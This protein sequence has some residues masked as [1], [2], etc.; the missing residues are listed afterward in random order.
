MVE[1][2]NKLEKL[3]EYFAAKRVDWS[4]KIRE[5]IYM[6]RNVKKLDE[7]IVL[8]LSY[9][10]MVLESLTELNVKSHKAEAAYKSQY[11]V[12]YM[13]YYNHDYKLNDKQKDSMVKADLIE[14][15]KQINLFENQIEFYRESIKTLDNM[16]WAIKSRISVEQM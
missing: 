16:G 15:R 4:D 3:E 6:M 8:M 2:E 10:Q 7:A 5:I 12:K 1:K 11:R 13:G 9:R 14:K